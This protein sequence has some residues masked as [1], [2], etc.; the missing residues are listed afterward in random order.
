[1]AA[2]SAGGVSVAIFNKIGQT[3]IAPVAGAQAQRSL[4]GV[5]FLDSN[6]VRIIHQQEFAR[7]R[8]S[9]R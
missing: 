1:M 8:A 5:L 9:L 7:W 2:V 3:G 4:A 6:A